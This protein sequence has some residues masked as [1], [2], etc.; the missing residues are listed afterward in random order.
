V[1]ELLKCCFETEAFEYIKSLAKKNKEE[2]IRFLMSLRKS[3]ARDVLLF[4]VWKA[5]SNVVSLCN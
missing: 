3:N 1:K 5:F 2:A 4:L